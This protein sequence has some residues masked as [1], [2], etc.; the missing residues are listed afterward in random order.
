[1]FV[2]HDPGAVDGRVALI[3][4]P[5]EGILPLRAAVFDEESDALR[6]ELLEERDPVSRGPLSPPADMLADLF[7]HVNP[8]EER[9]RSDPLSFKGRRS[10]C[11]TVI[12]RVPGLSLVAIFYPKFCFWA[13][14][15][16]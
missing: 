3:G 7:D 6:R 12:P 10:R 2:G 1:M 16:L 14:L 4:S 11:G 13:D 8:A 5:I 15:F 9:P